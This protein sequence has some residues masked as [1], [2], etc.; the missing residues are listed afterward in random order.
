MCVCVCVIYSLFTLYVFDFNT[1][2]CSEGYS[3]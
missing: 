1:I 3:L 2:H